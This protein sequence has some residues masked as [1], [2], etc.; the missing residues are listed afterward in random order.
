M[1]DNGLFHYHST[2]AYNIIIY[3]APHESLYTCYIYRPS[4]DVTYYRRV[5]I[6]NTKAS[7]LIHSI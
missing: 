7:T 5:L 3:I 6:N 1:N 2:S 4:L